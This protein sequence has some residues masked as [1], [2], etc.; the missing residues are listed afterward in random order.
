MSLAR[1]VFIKNRKILYN[2]LCKT[3]KR[4][5]IVKLL[6]GR[7]KMFFFF[8]FVIAVIVTGGLYFILVGNMTDVLVLNQ[9]ARGGT[10]ITA[11][12]LSVKKV[13][14]SSL[15][16]NY[17]TANYEDDVVGKYLDLG[18]TTNAVLTKDNL[19][20]TGKASLIE[21]GETL[22]AMS[23]LVNYP[24][25]LV[26]GDHVNV[27]VSTS[28]EGSKFVK[29]IENVPVA[30][31]HTEEGEITGI[32]VYVT[33]EEAQSIAYAQANGQVSVALLPLDYESK[34]LEILDDGGFLSSQ[35]GDTT[36]TES[37]Q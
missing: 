23:D 10:Q 31:V 12:M 18:L 6:K 17:L 9:T 13:D 16:D 35:F 26:A 34:N 28:A 33:P 14:K 37:A 21:T 30:G 8:L 29:T 1:S 27:V 3:E 20:L 4:G 25:G 2:Y 22:Y 15:P 7:N 32:E 24:Q 19:S 5:D 11:E 36:D